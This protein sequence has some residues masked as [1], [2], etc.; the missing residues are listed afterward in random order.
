VGETRGQRRSLAGAGAGQDEHWPLGGQHCLA[1]RRVQALQVSGL[2][3]RH[4]RFR[5]LHEVGKGERN[6]NRSGANRKVP[7][8][9][10]DIPVIHRLV[11]ENFASA[12]RRRCAWCS[13]DRDGGPGLLGRSARTRRVRQVTKGPISAGRQWTELSG[14]GRGQPGRGAGRGSCLSRDAAPGFFGIW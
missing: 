6:G 7:T 12:T 13:C 10:T 8:V 3:S 11:T 2:S 9:A 1:L 5:H 4:R 14:S